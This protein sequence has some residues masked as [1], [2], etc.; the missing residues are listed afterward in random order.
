M[1]IVLTGFMA[2]GK[3]NISRAL[4]ELAGMAFAD[5]DSMT[6]EAAGMTIN[7]IFAKYGEEKFRELESEAVKKAAVMENT[8]ISTGGG[9]VL[10][11]ENIDALRKN[12]VIVNLAPDFEVIKA[13][14]EAAAA[15]RPLM[16]GSS[17]DDIKRRFD[18]RKPFYDNCDIKIKVTNEGTPRGHA[19]EILNK[20]NE[21]TGKEVL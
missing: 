16:K 14:V 7:E 18:S 8:V 21:Y 3:T 11:K 10:R 1:N 15:T 2:S 4:A 19:Q 20:L 9:T 5:T 17:I 12:G 13:R 6:E